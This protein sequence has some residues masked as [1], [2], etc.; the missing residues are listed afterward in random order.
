VSWVFNMKKLILAVTLFSSVAHGRP[1]PENEQINQLLEGNKE[2]TSL[3]EMA[4]LSLNAGSTGIDLWSGHYWP[5]YQGSLAV[6]YH[7]PNFITL[8]T[9][10]EQWTK[11]KETFDMFPF[12]TYY[13]RENLLSPAEKYDLLVGDLTMS[14]TQYS[15][16][17][18]EEAQKLGRVPTW[19]GIC[20]GWSAAS[21]NMPRPAKSVT[22]KS[23]SAQDITFYPEDIKAL[24]SLLYSRAQKKVVFLG[25]RCLN[26]A[27]GVFNGACDGTNPGAYHKA[28]VNR[29]GSMKKTFVAD[30]STSSQVW[31][32]PVKSYKFT[33]VNVLNDKVESADFKQV[34]ELFDRP[35]KFEKGFSRHENTYAIVGVKAEVVYANMR[36]AHLL[37][38]DGKEQDK[39]MVKKYYYDL[40][41]D[42]NFNIL[43]GVWI[44]HSM[45]DFIWAPMDKAFPLSKAERS[46]RPLKE[47]ELANA[48]R[49]AS[50]VGQPLSQVV[51][52]LFTLSK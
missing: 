23:P 30:A 41:L 29:V 21:Q 36:E 27:V 32:Y 39:D 45:P 26:A 35:G 18:G 1:I 13:G 50:E 44:G 14:L 4:K 8:Q 47:N 48:A 24:G 3:N 38:T 20:D 31:N 42:S 37:D 17:L 11:F 34:M 9:T 7:D 19:R 22:L 46:N 2:I 5:H 6:R 12:Y 25:K 28:L 52:K 49:I 51:E 33:F 10:K 43:G 16:H 15:W 40:E